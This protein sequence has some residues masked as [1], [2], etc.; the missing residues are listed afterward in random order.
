MNDVDIKSIQYGVSRRATL[1][2]AGCCEWAF[3][4]VSDGSGNGNAK[5]RDQE[6]SE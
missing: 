5:K 4:W 2:D 6:D 3:P 1:G